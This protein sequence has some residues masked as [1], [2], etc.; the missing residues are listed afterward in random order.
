[1]K[2]KVIKEFIGIPVGTELTL[3]NNDYIYSYDDKE[4]TE[5]MSIRNTKEYTIDKSIVDAFIGEYFLR[6][7]E[8]D[9]STAK[10]I[11]QN[12]LKVLPYDDE[13]VIVLNI[14]K[15]T[16]ILNKDLFNKLFKTIN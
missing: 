3:I 10:F 8:L 14:D 5:G 1:M 9:W 13:N 6:I 4:I 15:T 7:D 2:V 12:A 11:R 16:T